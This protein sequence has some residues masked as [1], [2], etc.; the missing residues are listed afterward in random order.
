MAESDIQETNGKDPP[1]GIAILL[2]KGQHKLDP[3]PLQ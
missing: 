3:Y 2:G 1:N